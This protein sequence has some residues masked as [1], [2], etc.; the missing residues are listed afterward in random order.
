M[1]GETVGNVSRGIDTYSF[2]QPLGVVAGVCAFNF[3]AMIPLWMFPMVR[4]V[5]GAGKGGSLGG[6]SNLNVGCCLAP[7]VCCG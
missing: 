2:R 1:M 4:G 7:G 5:W 6:L 3:P